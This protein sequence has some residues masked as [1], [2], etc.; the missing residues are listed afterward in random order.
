MRGDGEGEGEGDQRRGSRTDAPSR[1][2]RIRFADGRVRDSPRGFQPFQHRSRSLFA[3]R[4][5]VD[6]C[7]S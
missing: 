2:S 6:R 1:S 7:N 3:N 4:V 5:S